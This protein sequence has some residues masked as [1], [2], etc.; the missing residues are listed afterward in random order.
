MKIVKII[1]LTILIIMIFLILKKIKNDE[2]NA[3]KTSV[4]NIDISNIENFEYKSHTIISLYLKSK[5]LGYKKEAKIA[6]LKLFKYMDFLLIKIEKEKKILNEIE[7][8]LLKHGLKTKKE[9]NIYDKIIETRK[10]HKK[11]KELN[12]NTK[13]KL[14][15]IDKSLSN[16]S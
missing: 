12:K 5:E 14:D 9:K 13:K 10:L 6:K 16:N 15:N 3:I 11:I 8:K 2:K 7:N 4:D 1:V